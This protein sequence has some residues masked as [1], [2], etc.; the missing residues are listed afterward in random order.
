MFIEMKVTGLNID[1]FTNMPFIILKDMKDQNTMPIWVGLV[2]ASSIATKLE[3]IELSRPMTHDLLYDM[4]VKLGAIVE[5]VAIEDVKENVFYS[6]VYLKKKRGRV[7]IDARPSDAI[8][9]ALRAKAPIM[10]DNDVIS[11]S[12][13]MDVAKSGKRKKDGSDSWKDILENLSPNDFGRY[14]M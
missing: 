13:K 11:A 9:L 5:K 12:K 14:K 4:I 1:P 8:A 7:I 10:V 6:K 2:E 3:N